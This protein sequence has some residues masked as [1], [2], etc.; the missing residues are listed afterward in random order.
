MG[1]AVYVTGVPK[2]TVPV[3]LAAIETLTGELLVTFIVI[4]FDVADD[5]EAHGALDVSITV[6]ISLFAREVVVYVGEFAPEIATPFFF[7]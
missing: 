5:G 4:P 6:M 7:H 3:G 1:V 2:Q